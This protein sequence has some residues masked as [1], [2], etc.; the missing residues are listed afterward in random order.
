MTPGLELVRGAPSEPPVDRGALLS[1]TAVAALIGGV[2]A[3]WVRRTVPHKLTLGHSTCRWF[4]RDVRD[5][6]ADRRAS[7]VSDSVVSS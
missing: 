1:A 7:A 3:A 2:S 4:E 5:W 6:L